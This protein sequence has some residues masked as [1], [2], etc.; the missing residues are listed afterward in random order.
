MKMHYES[1]EMEISRFAT[2]DVI[3]TSTTGGLTNGGT[4]TGG[5]TSFGD[6]FPELMNP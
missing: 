1:P 2:E 5:S 3:T 4:G 6:L